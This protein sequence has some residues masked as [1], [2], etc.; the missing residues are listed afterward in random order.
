MLSETEKEI[1][2]SDA[3]QFGSTN[4]VFLKYYLYENNEEALEKFSLQDIQQYN[5]EVHDV[6]RELPPSYVRRT[7]YIQNFIYTQRETFPYYSLGDIYNQTGICYESTV[8]KDT[9]E[10][11]TELS[12]RWKKFLEVSF[13]GGEK[14][15]ELKDVTTVKA[16]L[17][18][19]KGS[20]N[21]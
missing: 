11:Q 2:E 5:K 17:L 12:K 3:P 10:E 4:L 15:I 6:L 14:Y 13:T 20:D 8:T 19:T 18:K 9:K 1:L 7:F 21:L 16:K